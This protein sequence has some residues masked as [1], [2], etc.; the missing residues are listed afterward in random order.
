MSNTSSERRDPGAELFDK[1]FDSIPSKPV[2]VFGFVGVIT[3]TDTKKPPQYFQLDEEFDFPDN[4]NWVEVIELATKFNTIDAVVE[5]YQKII[6]LP[7]YKSSSGR[8]SNSPLAIALDIQGGEL[9]EFTGKFEI[10]ALIASPIPA[11]AT[12]TLKV[13]ADEAAPASVVSPE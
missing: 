8:I 11:R 1:I 4:V 13:E 2:A 10:Q 9:G 6:T 5:L 12:F 7:P 3:P